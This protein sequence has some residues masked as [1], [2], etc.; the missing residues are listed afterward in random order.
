MT[1]CLQAGRTGRAQPKRTLINARLVPFPPDRSL[2]F[3]FA[4]QT[5]SCGIAGFT[6]PRPEV[7]DVLGAMNRVP[8]RSG[9]S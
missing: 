9:R 4:K 7:R 5:Q 1:S 8:R 2:K 3:I 6:G